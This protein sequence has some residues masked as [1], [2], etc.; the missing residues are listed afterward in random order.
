MPEFIPFAPTPQETDIRAARDSGITISSEPGQVVFYGS[1]DITPDA[2]GL[3]AA[4]SLRDIV[5]ATIRRIEAGGFEQEATE[6]PVRRP[7]PLG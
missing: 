6:P 5:D 3:A 1:L 2:E 4:R 7:N